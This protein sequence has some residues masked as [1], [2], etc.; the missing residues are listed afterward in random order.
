MNG[1]NHTPSQAILTTKLSTLTACIRLALGIAVT[2]AAFTSP[3]F[4]EGTKQWA[5]SSSHFAAL[6]AMESNGGS[7]YPFAGYEQPEERRLHIHIADPANEIVYVGLGKL[8]GNAG[9]DI[10]FN[11]Y[12][13]IVAPDGSVVHG[14]SLAGGAQANITSHAQAVA[15]P[16]ALDP[17]GYSTSGNWTFDPAIA[18]KGAGDYYIE[19]DL[20][21]NAASAGS[22]TEPG[23]APSNAMNIKWFD[24]TVATKGGSPQAL[25]GRVWSKSW[26]VRTN[27]PAVFPSAPFGTP[28][29]GS[30]YAY[31]S[32]NFVTMINFLGSGLR[33]LQGQFSFN[34]TGTGSSGNKATDRKSVNDVNS[35][36]PQHKIF[37]NPPDTN[38]YPLGVDG[39]LQNLP[40]SINDTNN[41]DIKVEATQPGSVEVVLDIN[42]DG[43]YTA[44]IDRR[45]IE[46]VAAG[47]DSVPWDGKDGA[48]NKVAKSSFPIDVKIAYTQGETHF[49]AYDVEGLDNGFEV[50]TQTS[51]G[52]SGPNLLFW[53]DSNIADDPGSTPDRGQVNVDAGNT[54]RR[55]W[56]NNSYGDL[57]TINTWWFAYRDYQSTVLNLAPSVELSVVTASDAEASGGNLPVLVVSGNL[58]T[59]ATVEVA[60]SG[61]AVS[62]TDYNPAT[63]PIIITI[64]AG[65]Y[66]DTQIPIPGLSI[67]NESV[68]ESDDT[69]I[70]T[71]QNPANIAIDDANA[72]GTTIDQSTYTIVN[73]DFNTPPVATNDSGTTQED[74]PLNGTT[75]LANDSDIDNDT[76]TINTTPTTGPNNGSVVINANGTYTYTPNP[77]FNGTDSFEYEVSDGNGGTATATVTITVTPVNDPPVATNDNGTTQEDIPFNGSTVLT[78]DSD[79][80]GDTVTINTTPVTDPTNGSV[81]INPNGSYIYTPDQDFHGTD[82]FEYE[83]SDGNGGTDTATV[84]ITVTPV[85][86]N[87]VAVNDSATTAEDVVLHGSTILVNDSDVDGDTLTATTTPVTLPVHGILALNSNGTYTYTPEQNYNGTDSFVYAMTDGNGGTATATVDITITPVDDPPVITSINN[88]T[89]PENGTG[90]ALDVQSTDPDGDTENA[91]LTYNL[92]PL[93]DGGLFTINPNTGEI[94]FNTPPDYENPLDANADNAYIIMTEVCDSTSLCTQQVEVIVVTNVMETSPP[95]IISTIAQIPENQAF[96][97]DID[98]NDPD[99]DTLTFSITGGADAALFSIDPDSGELSFLNAPNFESPVDADGNNK[100]ELVITVTDNTA[101]DHTD[102]QSLQVVVTNTNEAPVISSDGASD[103]AALTHDENAT[104]VTTV[105]SADPDAGDTIT[106]TINGGSD[107]NLFSIDPATG[108]LRFKTAPDFE[109]PSDSDG[110]NTYVV[111]VMADDANSLFDLQTLTITVNDINDA[112]V[113]TSDGG[114]ATANVPVDENTTAVTTATSTDQDG[115][116]PVYSITGG[117]DAALFTID[118]A[119][120]ALTFTAA[121]DFENPTDVAGGTSAAGDNV[122]EVEVTSDDGNGGTDVQTLS[123]TVGNVNEPPA[124]TSDG[125]GDT[126]ALNVNENT[127]AVTTVIGADQD[128]ANTLTYSISGGVDAG[129]FAIDPATGT[130]TFVT[131]PDFENPTDVAGGTSTASD[132]VYEIAVTVSDSNGGTDVQALLVT[133][134][135]ANEAPTITS[136]GGGDTATVGAAENQTAVTTVTADDQDAGDTQGF[137]ISGGA[138]AALFT[139]DPA[140]GALSFISAPDFENPL[141]ANTDNSYEVAVTVSD[142]K[143]GTDVQTLSVTVTDVNDAPTITSNAGGDT[144]AVDVDENSTAITTVTSTDQDGATPT[145]SIAGGADA[146]LFTVDPTTGVLTFT[147]APDFENPNDANSDGIYEV[148]VKVDDSQGGTDEQALSITVLNVNDPPAITSDGAGDT[149]ALSVAENQ[150]VTTTVVAEDDDADVLAY[151]ISGG[152][153][154]ALFAINNVTGAL[155]FKDDPNFENPLDVAGGTSAAGDN[156]YEVEITANDGKGGT[157]KQM[158]SI[159]ITNVNEA[160]VISSNGGTTATTIHVDEE[161]PAVT[162]VAASDEDNNPL[163]YTITGG[164]DDHLFTIDPVTGVLTFVSVPDFESPADA[165]HNN[166][167]VVEITV[168]DGLGGYDVQTITVAVDNINDAPV[169]TSNG[170]GN[171]ASP[172]PEVAENTTTVT[173]VTSTD[174]DGDTPAYSISGGVDAALFTIDPVSGA[175]SFVSA[176]NFEAPADVAGG[177][178]AAG[179]NIYE[180]E[181][182]VADGNGGTD[183]QTLP[184]TVTNSNEAPVINSNGGGDTAGIT[185]GENTPVATT[186]AATD[187]DPA[188]TPTYSIS[189]GSDAGL[190]SIN[191]ATGE[192]TFNTAPDFENPT[193][194]NGDNVYE[195][196]VTADDGKGNTDTQ[197]LSITITDSNEAPVITSDGGGDAATPAPQVAE[198]STAVTTASATD[199]DAGDT[200]AWSISGGTDAALF[201]IDPATGVLSFISA[202]DFE[203]PADVAGGTSAAGD[204]VYEVEITVTDNGSLTDVQTLAVSVTNVNELPTITSDGGGDV[205]TPAPEVTEGTTAVTTVAS[206]DA[207]GDTPTYSLVGGADQ[208][209]FTIDPASGALSFVAAPDFENPTDADDNGIYEVIVKVDDGNGGTDEQAL[210][211]SVLNVNDPPVITSNGAGNTAALTV[212]ENQVATTIVKATDDDSDTLTYSLSGGVD[213]ALFAINNVTGE[214]VFVDEPNFEH[215]LDAA[216]GTSAA[217]DNIYEVQISVADG[218]G[219]VDTQLLSISVADINEAPVVTSNGGGT[220]TTTHVPEEQTAVT[221]V[222]ATDEDTADTQRYT[223]TGGPDDHL[224]AIDPATGVLTFKTAPDYESPVDADH[225]NAYIVEVTVNDGNGG[226]DVQTLTVVVDNTNDAPAITSNGAGDSAHLTVDENSTPATIVTAT[227]EDA[228][229]LAFSIVGGDDAS[230]FSI[231]PATGALTFVT[232]PDVE[233]PADTNADNTYLVNVMVED[234]NGGSDTQALEIM[235]SN[236]NESPEIT[237]GG[238]GTTAALTQ[239]EGILPVTTVSSTDPD[240]DTPAYGISGGTDGSLFTIDPAS[241]ELGFTTA[242]DFE[243]PADSDGNNVYEVTVAVTDGGGKQDTQ[244]LSITITDDRKVVLNVRAFLQGAYDSNT[245]L[246]ADN[247]HSLG[248]LPMA[249][250][251]APA[252]ISH[253]GSETLNLDLALV[254]GNEAIVDWMLVDLRDAAEP[255]TILKTQAVMVQRDGDLVN[256]QTGSADLMF[257]DTLAGD[258]FVSVRHRNH[259][260][261]MTATPVHLSDLT[262]MVDFT[263][264]ATPAYGNHARI[265]AGNTALLWAGDANQTQQ[266]IAHGQFNDVN[267]IL[268]NVLVKDGKNLDANANYRLAGY[269]VTDINM[270]G[271][272]LYAGPGNDINLLLGNVLLH[273]ANSTFAA[274]YIVNGTLPK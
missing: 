82:S 48:G 187:D 223:I 253:A 112:P 208:D 116:T 88:V 269:E 101:P 148:I 15:G 163:A 216:G 138:D 131:A 199:A 249:Q 262:S 61:T 122:Y 171:A 256:A 209:K 213:V 200:K 6:G 185:L 25:D 272:T 230:Q 2:S 192:L 153:D 136:N 28:F 259:M 203:N 52:P 26:G 183:V 227:D 92:K 21:D 258:Y 67:T 178:S 96:V 70:L 234:G 135:D 225:N 128:T 9:N 205:A 41:A 195:V 7:A 94:T 137:S 16:S 121:P 14:S 53:D 210:S 211:I 69:L 232:A 118:P 74:I 63:G 143:G 246:M 179:D 89:Y 222:A 75:L 42:K 155:V 93:Y 165:D 174:E 271:I 235:V 266:I 29:N 134:V 115:D 172:A 176:P 226:Y 264:T 36:T 58:L 120:G 109:N 66:A 254:T 175:L 245:G 150:V 46:N 37:L 157:D 10:D 255:K 186:V 111:Q 159:T 78:N 218:K 104:A 162:T 57:N 43:S 228:D 268:G 144:Y 83:V 219:G 170:A 100:Y 231:D 239:M 129:L 34:N 197:V 38:I 59:D 99:P 166:Q 55:T 22:Y 84:T 47:V 123:V 20:N 145:Y 35:G 267:M 233:N 50:F 173:T 182:T 8:T 154:A 237:S 160:P 169:I 198:N 247:L 86:D 248:I 158:L 108:E 73:D 51:S 11:F 1:A 18:G 193:D 274:N 91:G 243:N 244:A 260:G 65:N 152:V 114:A 40:L 194:G 217:S 207:D 13:R 236:T 196:A 119:T 257:A 215:P 161:Q 241:G 212:N 98:A 220:T 132:N 147:T 151:S 30:M 201:S 224:F 102:S 238:A 190:F 139:I 156:I 60:L 265:E 202:P 81:V 113:I 106:Y 45:L 140:T 77:N 127:I 27:D 87:P 44:G 31:D 204:N 5:P 214:L 263:Q 252:P 19:F 141:D 124:I 54:L 49:T 80:D 95:S 191:P 189:G 68:V 23:Y 242:P 130:L 110:N 221:T 126:A 168:T 240:G 32:N 229:T 64:P 107:A 117:A 250:P 261:V 12:W 79:I 56:S 177:T 62:G 72:N 125:G 206:N 270:D 273:P 181:V 97:T 85:N 251:Y 76:L 105:T 33:P 17:A 146:A 142:G 4:A 3:A 167:Y 149:A 103:T 133:V 24:I 180:V 39:S 184:V 164:P 71:L 90:T 188:D